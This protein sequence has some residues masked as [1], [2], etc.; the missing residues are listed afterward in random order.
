MT[1]N[2]LSIDGIGPMPVSRPGNVDELRELVRQAKS[3]GQPVFPRGGATQI[4]MGNPPARP[5]RIVD[6]RGLD[7]VLDYPARD[8]TITVQAGITLAPLQQIL[9]K[10]NQRLPIDVPRASE[11]TLGGVVAANVS[12]P[13]RFGFGTLRDYVIGVSAIND[14]GEE[15]K[16][17][18]RVVKN[19][20]GY[21][22]C[23]LLVGSLGTLG[24]ITQ[25]T[26]KL[27]PLAE[28]SELV[29][30]TIPDARL[31]E[32]LD[33]IHS[34]R[35]RPVA[36]ELLDSQRPMQEVRSKKDGWTLLVGFEGNKEAVEWQV[37]QLQVEWLGQA[38]SQTLGSESSR[39][40]WNDLITPPT[41]AC[42]FKANLLPSGVAEFCRGVKS[43]A[44]TIQSHAASGIVLGYGRVGLTV[45]EA[46]SMLNEWRQLAAAR[47]GK[48]IVAACPSEW[49]KS[50]NVWGPESGDV[51][52]MREV[53]KKLDPNNLFNPGRFVGGI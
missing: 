11:A 32:G 30:L 48:V 6:M 49:K 51:W 43:D 28:S 7:G 9:A 44:M 16:A 45:E 38:E 22:M 24:I 1:D 50:L 15:F 5:G 42:V 26:L 27:R 2:S 34:T 13:R 35:T 33:R 21:D 39:S 19:V 25:I 17:G 4:G 18:G 53:K 29:A 31:G 14:E 52:L 37:K 20:A 23:K 36:V 3:E 8:M 12:G 46:A 47:Q 41:N 10:E 40:T